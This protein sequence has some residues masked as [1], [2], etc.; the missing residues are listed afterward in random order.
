MPGAAGVSAVVVSGHGKP[1]QHPG[2]MGD[3]RREQAWCRPW[4]RP[5]GMT[6]SIINRRS[7]QTG[8]KT[9]RRFRDCARNR[10]PL[11]GQFQV[12]AGEGY[13]PGP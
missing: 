12:R 9:L 5:T 4:G 11:T 2:G 7:Q 6:V 1:S 10:W 8:R 3:G 13:S